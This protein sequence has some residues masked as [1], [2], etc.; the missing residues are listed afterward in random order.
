MNMNKLQ[1]FKD[2]NLSKVKKIICGVACFGLVFALPTSSFAEKKPVNKPA[3]TKST[4]DDEKKFDELKMGNET[5]WTCENKVIVKTA[6]VGNNYLLLFN[7]KLYTMNGIE[8]L[9]GVSHFTD[10]VNRLD[11]FIIPGKAMLFDSKAGQRLLDYCAHSGLAVI[12][13]SKEVDLMK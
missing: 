10:I 13:K 3:P 9:N 7:K 8:A 4:A 11:W 6:Q 2:S 12:D 5:V 1:L